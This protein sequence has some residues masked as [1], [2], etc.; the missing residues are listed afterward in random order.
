MLQRVAV[1]ADKGKGRLVLVMTLVNAPVDK[2]VMEDPVCVVEE[3]F[4]SQHKGSPFED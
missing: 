2:P 4:P 1:D 3:D